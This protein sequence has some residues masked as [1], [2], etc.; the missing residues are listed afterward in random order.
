M[1]NG[2]MGNHG[3]LIKGDQAA[4]QSQTVEELKNMV[5]QLTQIIQDK[6]ETI[7]DMSHDHEE[8]L[9]RLMQAHEETI[10]KVMQDREESFREFFKKS[11]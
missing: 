11:T 9:R 7:R 1:G 8:T 4:A 3:K 10:R 2:Y 6:E 5:F